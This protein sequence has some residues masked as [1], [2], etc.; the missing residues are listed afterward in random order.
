MALERS[1]LHGLDWLV[2]LGYLAVVVV[3][4]VVFS[5]RGQRDTDDYFLAG[6]R[7]PAWAVACSIVATAI[8]AATFIGLPAQSYAGDLTFLSASIGQVL[9]AVVVAAFFLPA[10]YRHNVSTVYQLLGT[11]FGEPARL[12]ASGMFLLGR[13]F[14]DG[15]RVYIAAIAAAMIVF[16]E[17]AEGQLVEPGHLLVGI[18]ALMAVGVGYTLV[19]GIASVIWTNVVQAGVFLLAIAATLVLLWAR[20]PLGLGQVVDVLS[21]PGPGEASKLTVLN[22]GLQPG[23]AWLGFDPS[24]SYTLVTALGCFTLFNMAAYGTDHELA[25]RMLTCSSPGKGGRSLIGAILM[26]VPFTALFLLIG[27]LLYVYHRGLA[28]A[29]AGGGAP[30]ATVDAAP[31]VFLR[32]MLRQMPAGVLGLSLA[33]LFAAAL[34]S[35]NSSLN[36]MAATLVT[37]FYKPW[38][39]GREERDYL[40]VGRAAVV[41][42]GVV[43]TLFAGLCV[44]WQ[45]HSGQTLIDFALGV[46]TFAYSGLLGVFLTAIFTRR[47]SSGSAVA[48]MLGGFLVVLWLQPGVWQGVWSQVVVWAEAMGLGGDWAR[49]AGALRLAYPWRMAVATGVSFVVACSGRPRGELAAVAERAGSPCPTRV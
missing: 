24:Q 28:A 29:G 22:V 30:V 33:G 16:G 36:A 34:S 11:R 47:G 7:M 20:I 5:R 31:S 39:P 21:D 44:Y 45:R 42:W 41:G 14:A 2:L 17:P 38:R 49:S 26:S 12:I 48:A 32:F 8:S 25:Q 19:G 13:V 46:M 3:T 43:Q 35:I 37:D 27:L 6:R 1:A 4:G 18:A 9:A 15:A 10:F 23:S 40:R